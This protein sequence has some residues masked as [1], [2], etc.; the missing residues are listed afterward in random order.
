MGRMSLNVELDYLK[1]TSKIS[2]EGSNLRIEKEHCTYKEGALWNLK[3]RAEPNA[4][5][6]DSSLT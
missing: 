4:I 6:I 3:S 2:P 1:C 5:F